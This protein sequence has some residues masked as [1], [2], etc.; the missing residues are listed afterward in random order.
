MCFYR[1]YDIEL[2]DAPPPKKKAE[3]PEYVMVSSKPHWKP[4]EVSCNRFL[5]WR[6]IRRESN[7]DPFACHP[8]SIFFDHS[9]YFHIFR[10]TRIASFNRA[11]IHLIVVQ[12]HFLCCISH[13]RLGR[14]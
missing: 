3:K 11:G 2:D 12:L 7:N 9:S 1:Y 8:R 13:H 10:W 14:V 6:V 5:P 4:R